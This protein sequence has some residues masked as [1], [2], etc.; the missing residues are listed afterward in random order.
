MAILPTPGADD[1]CDTAQ[2]QIEEIEGVFEGILE[3]VKLELK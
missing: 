1:D 3:S 2:A